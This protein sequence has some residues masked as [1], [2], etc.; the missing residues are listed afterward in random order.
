MQTGHII[1]GTVLVTVML[2]AGCATDSNDRSVVLS[3]PDTARFVTQEQA[4][5]LTAQF[6]RQAA[7][8]RELAQRT[9]WEADWYA[10]QYGVNDQKTAMSLTQ[11]QQLWAA[12]AD[13]DQLARDYRRQVPH[14][15]IY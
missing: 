11:A 3:H 1:R 9:Q 14:G 13:A 12:A 10:R 5:D 2:L 6:H 4:R 15:Q 7:D 8:I